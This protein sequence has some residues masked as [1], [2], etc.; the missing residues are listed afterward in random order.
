MTAPDLNA[1]ADRL[2]R[3]YD[4]HP[5]IMDAA[6]ALRW[7]DN[8]LRTERARFAEHLEAWRVNHATLAARIEELEKT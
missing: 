8:E 3:I 6:A 4:T 5:I 1:L 2:S 7:A